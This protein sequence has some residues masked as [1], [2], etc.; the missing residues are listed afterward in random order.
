[1]L[2][3]TSLPKIRSPVTSSSPITC[4]AMRR[5]LTLTST[6]ST[7]CTV[8]SSRTKKTM[9]RVRRLWIFTGGPAP[10][11]GMRRRR[12]VLVAGPACDQRFSCV[13][14]GGGVSATRNVA[15]SSPAVSVLILTGAGSATIHGCQ[16]FNT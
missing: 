10:G 8:T 5:P 6:N 15:A 2:W 1:M 7:A 9:I 13:V 3:A 14:D 11:R 4:S 12:R 16:A